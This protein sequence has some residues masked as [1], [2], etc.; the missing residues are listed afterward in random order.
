M[1][2]KKNIYFLVLVATLLWSGCSS[3][4]SDSEEN[5]QVDFNSG[6]I[7]PD[8]SFSYTFDEEGTVEYYCEIHAPDMQGEITVS[9]SADST[10]SDTVI[11]ENLQFNP[12][13]LTV[14]PGTEV[15]WI[16]QDNEDHTVVSG[17]PSS[18]G[19]SGY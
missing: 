3:T 19:G 1:M 2:Y 8:E 5:T 13:E 6:R 14:A 4:G 12:S 11:M 17:N 18:D 15:I 10:Q 16:N 9:S 7:A